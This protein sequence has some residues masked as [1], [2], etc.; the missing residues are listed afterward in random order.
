M[1]R[2]YKAIYPVCG[3]EVSGEDQGTLDDPSFFVI[4]PP[5]GEMIEVEVE[6]EGRGVEYE[7]NI[8]DARRRISIWLIS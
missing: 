1:K 3:V 5:C 6:E 7:A 8:H 4:C 2:V